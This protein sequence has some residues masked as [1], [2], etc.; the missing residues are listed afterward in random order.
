VNMP[1]S[2]AQFTSYPLTAPPP[3][4]VGEIMSVFRECES[5][6]CTQSL[7]KGLTSDEVLA[8]LRPGLSKLGFQIETGK[9]KS[10]KLERPVFFGENGT[11]TLTYQI[12]AF[13]DEWQCGLEVEAGRAKMGNAIYRDLIQALV[14]VHVEYLVLA[15]PNVYKY[16]T[17]DRSAKSS[18]YASAKKLAQALYN[19]D[20]MKLP[21]G[22]ILIGY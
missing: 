21:Y 15:V 1:T 12:D 22:L 19:H 17:G 14:M 6:I 2:S 3:A 10:E 7:S 16:K 9:R 20:R 11:P 5:D 4:F 13:H 18:D 8:R